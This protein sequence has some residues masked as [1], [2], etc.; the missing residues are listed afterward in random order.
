MSGRMGLGGGLQRVQ[1][2][3]AGVHTPLPLLPVCEV[4]VFCVCMCVCERGG[5]G[6]GGV[7]ACAR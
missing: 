5:R 6:R 1:A 2:V 3:L 4:D 7:R